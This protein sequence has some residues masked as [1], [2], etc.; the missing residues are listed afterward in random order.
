MKRKNN[1][2]SLELDLFRAVLELRTEEECSAFFQDLC[3]AAEVEE[4][5]DRWRV[6][7]MLVKD[8]SYRQIADEANVSTTTVGR[9]ARFLHNGHDGYKII[10]ERLGKL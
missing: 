9:V 8:M 4:F 6:A 1:E 5:A 2:N 10:L 3:T 7:Q